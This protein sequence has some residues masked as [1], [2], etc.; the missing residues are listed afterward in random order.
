MRDNEVI[1]PMARAVMADTWG[2]CMVANTGVVMLANLILSQKT[3]PNIPLYR[4]D[5]LFFL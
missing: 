3:E 4:A 1:I 2:T 5:Y